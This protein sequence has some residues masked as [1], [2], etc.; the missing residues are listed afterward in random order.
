MQWKRR[1]I[2]ATLYAKKLK[3][4]DN[5]LSISPPFWHP[6]FARAFIL[7]WDGVVVETNLDFSP[8]YGRFFGG[9]RVMLL[10]VMQS[11]PQEVRTEVWRCL[12]EIETDGASR[13]QPVPGSLELL[14]WLE[15]RNVPWGIVSRNSKASVEIAAKRAGIALPPVVITRDEKVPVKPAP[16]AFWKASE[17]MG[18]EP[19]CAVV[20]G[21]FLYDLIGARRAGMRSVL[22]QRMDEGWLDWIEVAYPTLA[23]FVRSLKEPEP[24]TPWEYRL[25]EAKRGR[26]WLKK[27]FRLTVQIPRDVRKPCS[28]AVTAATLGVGGIAVPEDLRLEASHW[29]NDPYFEMVDLWQPLPQTLERFMKSRFPMTK[30]AEGGDGFLLPADPAFLEESLRALVQ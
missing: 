30:I 5:L 6:A 21:D 7:D 24:L 19:S 11:L 16:E 26:E 17:L 3:E 15:E 20:V 29:L 1:E 18:V 8:V 14:S 22:V 9:K 2:D 27:C 4:E 10:E 12:E 25:L 28:W 23:D 13:A